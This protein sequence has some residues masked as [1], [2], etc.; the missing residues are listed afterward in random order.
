MFMA[1]AALVTALATGRRAKVF[2]ASAALLCGICLLVL[3]SRAGGDIPPEAAAIIAI[4][5]TTWFWAALVGS[6]IL[7]FFTFNVL[8]NK[9]SDRERPRLVIQTYEK[10]VESEKIPS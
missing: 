1:L 7:A 2:S 8:S 4:E 5:W 9:D 6:G 10:P 3:K